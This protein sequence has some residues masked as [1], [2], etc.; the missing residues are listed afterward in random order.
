MKID[1][2]Q[3]KL[4]KKS[5][6]FQKL[7]NIEKKDI[8]VKN[9]F[10]ILIKNSREHLKQFIIYL[11]F[12]L[13]PRLKKETNLNYNEIFDILEKKRSYW[14]VNFY[15]EYNGLGLSYYIEVIKQ[16]QKNQENKIQFAKAF[17][18]GTIEMFCSLDK[19]KE[20]CVSV[21]ESIVYEF[22]KKESK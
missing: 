21:I 16:Y 5:E 6:A 7:I 14:Y 13:L 17:T 2:E 20:L 1:I 10:P 15:G 18:P 22:S 9:G 4:L 19:N 12:S 11:Y 8:D 3:I